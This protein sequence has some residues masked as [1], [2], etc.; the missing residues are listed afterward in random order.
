MSYTFL[1]A[2]HL[3]FAVTD[4]INH[5]LYFVI[6]AKTEG[7]VSDLKNRNGKDKLQIPVITVHYLGVYK[8][9]NIIDCKSNSKTRRNLSVRCVK[10]EGHIKIFTFI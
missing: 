2:L 1:H 4:L 5:G 9:S 7:T 10:R 8:T 3:Y 6:Q